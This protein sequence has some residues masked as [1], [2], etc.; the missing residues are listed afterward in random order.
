MAVEAPPFAEGEADAT[1]PLI[2][3][4]G[5]AE[6]V[7]VSETPWKRCD[8]YKWQM[9]GRRISTYN[10][11]TCLLSDFLG[12][13]EISRIATGSKAGGR[14]GYEDRVGAQALQVALGTNVVIRMEETLG[15]ARCFQERK[16][17]S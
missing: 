9:I 15:R 10:F 12:S 4:L 11:G 3:E 6:G 14:I 16:K 17:K 7:E 2:T 1:A 13:C 5:V 8:Y